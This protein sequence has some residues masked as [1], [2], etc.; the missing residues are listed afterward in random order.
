MNVLYFKTQR[1]RTQNKIYGSFILYK[2]I[3]ISQQIA[4]CCADNLLCKKT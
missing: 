4:Y 1:N 3:E 2:M